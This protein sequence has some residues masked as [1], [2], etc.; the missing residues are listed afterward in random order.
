MTQITHT[1]WQNLTP[2]G[3]AELRYTMRSTGMDPKRW[4]HL[5][6]EGH[7][8]HS[9]EYHSVIYCVEG[10]LRF[11]LTDEEDRQIELKPGD[12]L[13]IPAGIRH[14]AVAGK[15]GGAYLEGRR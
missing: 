2:P 8:A 3:E 9:H 1:L 6:G 13:D 11:V 4:T 5:A 14:L 12:R 10:S 7:S 15:D